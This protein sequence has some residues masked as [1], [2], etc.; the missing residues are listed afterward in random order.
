VPFV[1]RSRPTV[2]HGHLVSSSRALTTIVWFPEVAGRHPLVVFASGFQVGPA[3]YESMLSAWASHGYVV[4]APEF[5]LTDSAIAGANLD[6]SDINNQ[7]ADLRFITNDLVAAGS[8]VAARIYRD[9]VALAGHS[10]GAESALSASLQTTAAGEPAY[11]AI[12]AMSVQP[13]TSGPS[14]NPPILITQGDADTINPFSFGSDT[15][16]AAASP[17]YFLVLHGGE[18][19][20]P[21]EAGSSW[22]S[23]VEAVTEAFLDVYVEHDRPVSAIT[24]AASGWPV[25]TLQSG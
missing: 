14:A 4:A 10:D 12:I 17:K 25:L 23:G 16:R 2:S 24:T 21:L 9:Q 5:P 22:L 15:W 13:V 19:L 11:R 1:D 8:P 7:P 20:S 6:E 3:P 18:H